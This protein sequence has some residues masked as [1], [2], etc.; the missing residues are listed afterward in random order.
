MEDPPVDQDPWP[1]VQD[2]QADRCSSCHSPY[3]RAL[4]DWRVA[5]WPMLLE[6]RKSSSII[7]HVLVTH[8]ILIGR[9]FIC[10]PDC[11]YQD[12]ENLNEGPEQSSS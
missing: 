2:V 8:D 7:S 9:W 11:R 5:I 10:N 6:A 3:R 12:Q 1:E 4:S